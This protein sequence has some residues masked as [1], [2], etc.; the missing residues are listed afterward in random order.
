MLANF[1]RL[2]S[3]VDRNNPVSTI[4]SFP[5]TSDT[6]TTTPAQH[7][8]ACRDDRLLSPVTVRAHD[9]AAVRRFVAEE[10]AALTA[11]LTSSVLP[12]K[13]PSVGTARPRRPK[14]APDPDDDVLE[15]FAAAEFLHLHHTTVR[16]R[17]ELGEIPG[18]KL[19]NRW[20]FSRKRLTVWLAESA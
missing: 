3:Q 11:L 15:P 2:I 12:P 19:G 14:G 6:T 17:A 4:M 18:R 20:R 13:K 5:I 9:T 7:L 16:E 1:G 8:A 10:A